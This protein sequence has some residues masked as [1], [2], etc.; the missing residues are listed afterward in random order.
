MSA[1]IEVNL[2]MWLNGKGLNSKVI[3]LTLSGSN[4]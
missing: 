2:P 4:I 1:Q 3:I